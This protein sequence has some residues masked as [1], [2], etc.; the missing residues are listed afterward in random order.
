[1]RLA[2]RFISREAVLAAAETYQFGRGDNVRVGTAYFRDSGEW[3]ADFKVR[4]RN[5][6]M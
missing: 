6:E 2:G 1:M 3:Q 5:D 4:R